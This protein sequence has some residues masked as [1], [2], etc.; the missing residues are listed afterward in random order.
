MGHISFWL[1]V[2]PLGDNKYKAGKDIRLQAV[3]EK[4]KYDFLVSSPE[5]RP[6][7]WIADRSFGNVALFKYLR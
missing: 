1:M 2:N 4:T 5:C 6:I 7:S 3:V